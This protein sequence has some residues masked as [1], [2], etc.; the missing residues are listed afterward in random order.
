MEDLLKRKRR[1]TDGDA[2]SAPGHSARETFAM[3][4]GKKVPMSVILAVGVRAK[5]HPQELDQSFLVWMQMHLF[6]RQPIS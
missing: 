2:G 6:R 1:N 4:F 3:L 5:K